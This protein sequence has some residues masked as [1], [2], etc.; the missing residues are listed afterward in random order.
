MSNVIA[1]RALSYTR[2]F[3]SA[4][5]GWLSYQVFTVTVRPFAARMLQLW[6]EKAIAISKILGFPQ[7]KTTTP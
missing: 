2:W 1:L 7:P 6:E 5:A 3:F 4:F